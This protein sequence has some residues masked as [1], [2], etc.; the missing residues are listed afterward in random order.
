MIKD[1]SEKEY[2]AIEKNS[3]SSLKDFTLNRR[4]YY[5]R[6][7]LKDTKEDDDEDESTFIKMGRLVETL[8]MEPE[9]FDDMF[10][11]SSCATPPT[12]MMLDFVNALVK[13]TI[14]ATDKKGVLGKPFADL[15]EKAYIDSKFKL[16]FETI[17]EKFVGSDAEI[18][19]NE[20]V[21]VRFNGLTVVTANDIN[22]A[23]RIVK[24]LQ[25]NVV[26][27]GIVNL[28]SGKNFTVINQLK[29]SDFEIHGM[30][31]KAMLDKIIVNHS[32]K[33]IRIFDLKCTW[34]VENFYR[35][36]YLKLRAYIQGYTYYKAVQYLTK[37]T[38]SEFYGYEVLPPAFIVCDSINYFNPLIYEMT[39]DDLKEAFLG[40]ESKGGYRYEGVKEIINNLNF[41]IDND[42]WNISQTNYK[43]NGVIKIQ[44]LR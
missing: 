43:N 36:Y 39:Q 31:M 5:K 11:M 32:E 38:T 26:T 20:L 33:T 3:S 15:L 12:A 4:K 37:D 1:I 27:S 19:Y 2:R 14:E 42:V 35:E 9:K 30:P 17:V 29:I 21:K 23:E 10:F 40:F 13:Y 24:E 18:Y 16:K 8:L 44:T 41:A 6:Y 28:S 7:I 34:S 22:N 25:T